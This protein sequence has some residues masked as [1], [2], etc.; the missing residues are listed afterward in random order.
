[1]NLNKIK[2]FISNYKKEL[3]FG[4][5]SISIGVIA[6]NVGIKKREDYASRLLRY[7][8]KAEKGDVIKIIPSDLSDLDFTDLD[9]TYPYVN[10]LKREF[11]EGVKNFR[12]VVSA[13][14]GKR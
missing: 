7:L 4:I 14:Y 3:I 2:R 9:F 13:N 5:A 12:L 6:Y 11:G 1:M 10:Y 8:F